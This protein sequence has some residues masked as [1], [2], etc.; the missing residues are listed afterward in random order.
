M[1]WLGSSGLTTST[2]RPTAKT[3]CSDD[4]RHEQ[5]RPLRGGRRPEDGQAEQ[6]GQ[7][8]RHLP[9][10]ADE[11]DLRQHAAPARRSGRATI[12]RHVRIAATT[13]GRVAQAT[14]TVAIGPSSSMSLTS[15]PPELDERARG[16]EVVLGE[17]Q[18]AR[19]DERRDE[20]HDRGGRRADRRRV[21]TPAAGPSGRCPARR[22]GA[23]TISGDRADAAAHRDGA[24]GRRPAPAGR[25]GG[26]GRRAA[27][28]RG[29]TRS[30]R[31]RWRR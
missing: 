14:R 5:R 10:E 12:A 16:R 28:R 9:R 24:R 15:R 29:R 1:A 4:H 21:S 18:A 20:E 26:P 6:A 2:R 3:S 13:A 31:W 7:Q 30:R 8:V 11:Q 22:T 23:A 25:R 19:I 27:R 17:R